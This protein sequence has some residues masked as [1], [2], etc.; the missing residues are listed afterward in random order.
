M[1]KLFFINKQVHI[2]HQVLSH[3]DNSP[4]LILEMLWGEQM[5]FVSF[6]EQRVSLVKFS[7]AHI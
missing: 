2:F 4:L 1:N 5:L 3:L 7:A 6:R